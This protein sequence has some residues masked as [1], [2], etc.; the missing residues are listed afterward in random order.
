[1]IRKCFEFLGLLESKKPKP[2]WIYES[3]CKTL[4]GILLLRLLSGEKKKKKGF[5]F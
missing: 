1:M 3:G 2:V 4:D 5:I